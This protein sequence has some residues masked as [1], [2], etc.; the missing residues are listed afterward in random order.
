MCGSRSAAVRLDEIFSQLVELRK[1]GWEAQKELRGMGKAT[2]SEQQAAETEFL[3]TQLA[4]VRNRQRLG[5]N[6][7]TVVGLRAREQEI[8][9]RIRELY[10][11]RIAQKDQQARSFPK[12]AGELRLLK[13]ESLTFEL[14]EARR[15]DVAP[16]ALQ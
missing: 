14:D 5:G 1:E 8:L 12:F 9:T 7:E 6:A 15:E 13:I 16:A 2:K 10:A 3:K 11:E 4:Q